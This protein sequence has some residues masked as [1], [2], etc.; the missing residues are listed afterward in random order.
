MD[1][2]E[3]NGHFMRAWGWG[4]KD[5]KLEFEICTSSCVKGQP[6]GEDEG[7]FESPTGVA[8]NPTNGDVYISDSSGVLRLPIQRF[9][10]G[11]NFLGTVGVEEFLDG[12]I[13]GAFG[14]PYALATDTAGDLYVVDGSNGR[15]QELGP[16]EEFLRM[17][18]RGVHEGETGPSE[19]FG[20]CTN[21]EKCQR[22][23]QGEEAGG[24]EFI[25]GAPA[26]IAIDPSGNVWVPDPGN[27]R[28][29]EFTAEG[30]FVMAFGWGVKD[31]MEKFETCT[32]TCQA[33]YKGAQ[34]P[35]FEDPLGAAAAPTGCSIYVTD[36]DANDLVDEFGCGGSSE[37]QQPPG[38]QKEPTG[39][40]KSN[41][42]PNVSTAAGS[43]S[44]TGSSSSS[45][46]TN[47]QPPPTPAELEERLATAFGLPSSKLCYSKRSFKIHIQQPHGYPKVVSAKV[48]LGTMPERSLNKKGLT[49]EVVLKR[50]PYGTFTIRIVA[51]TASGGKLTGTQTYHTCRSKPIH[52]HGH[53]RL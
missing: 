13:R 48:F 14:E 21:K 10:P 7:G 5:S 53:P 3:P 51:R 50:P 46:N 24:F 33:G 32:T 35:E 11:G 40:P 16:K 41:Q 36:A 27:G 9:S 30:A 23:G 4:V 38:G 44:S 6:H 45:G 29:Q 18:G 34:P 1:E 17:W 8:V 26:S 12:P 15:V 25:K 37:P 28:V 52:P 47:N 20:V 43:A 49:D 22:G 19:H 39:E 31:K 2:F 42:P